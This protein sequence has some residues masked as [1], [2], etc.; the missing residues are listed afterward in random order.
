VA[1]PSELANERA[2][3]AS[4]LFAG[5]DAE[6]LHSLAATAERRQLERGA[7]LWRAGDVATRFTVILSGLVKIVRSA[8]DGTETIVGIFGPRESVGDIAVLQ[9]GA[10][11]ADAVAVSDTLE[12]LRVDAAPMLAAKAKN[13]KVDESITRTL[14]EHTQLLHQK[15]Q[16]M[17]AGAIPKRLA[18]LV[19]HL[20]ERFGDEEES[21]ATFVPIVLSRTELARLVGATVETTIRT[22]SG[23]QKQQLL[24]TT[25]E[26]FRIPDIKKLVAVTSG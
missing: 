13:P 17:S 23:W 21:G 22:M 24:L 12:V 20:A 25:P 3:G 16:I 8:S 5:I 10:Y 1:T 4:R 26:G 6:T 2:L 7:R 11:P 9:R 14:I 19:L 15:I 18:T